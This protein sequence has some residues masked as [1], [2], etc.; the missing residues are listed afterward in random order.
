MSEQELMV[1]IQQAVGMLNPLWAIKMF[2]HVIYKGR[3]RTIPGDVILLFRS[4]K[5]KRMIKN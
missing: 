1:I 2:A 3:E 5:V 4:W